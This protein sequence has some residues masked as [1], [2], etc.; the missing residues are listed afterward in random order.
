MSIRKGFLLNSCFLPWSKTRVMMHRQANWEGRPPAGSGSGS[1][2]G[3]I[4]GSSAWMPRRTGRRPDQSNGGMSK[5]FD[6]TWSSAMLLKNQES[7]CP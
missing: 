6:R 2:V 4:G 1:R 5:V 7:T 3:S